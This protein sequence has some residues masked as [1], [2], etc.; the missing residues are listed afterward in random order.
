MEP[1]SGQILYLSKDLVSSR[2]EAFWMSDGQKV[3]PAEV[4]FSKGT[5]LRVLKVDK[6]KKASGHLLADPLIM[7][8]SQSKSSWPDNW[9]RTTI[10]AHLLVER[11]WESLG[12]S[13]FF[14]SICGTVLADGLYELI[15]TELETYVAVKNI[16]FTLLSI[17]LTCSAYAQIGQEVGDLTLTGHIADSYGF[18]SGY[19][20]EFNAILV[21][22]N[23]NQRPAKVTYRCSNGWS[24]RSQPVLI[25]EGEA[26]GNT[27]AKHLVMPIVQLQECLSKKAELAEQVRKEPVLLNLRLTVRRRN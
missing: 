24:S 20:S 27:R 12:L 2:T 19:I 22:S 9:L 1:K 26:L 15:A 10:C 3:R 23:G 21:D 6:W 4:A 14:K 17:S 5:K 8:S 16:L 11:K 18:W 13:S 7:T 25:V